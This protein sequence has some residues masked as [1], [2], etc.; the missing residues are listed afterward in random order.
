MSDLLIGRE[1]IEEMSINEMAKHFFALKTKIDEMK[2]AQA[3]VQGEFDML[4]KG[5][6]PDKMDEME[7][8][9]VNIAGVG[10]ISLRAEVY[11]SVKK[12]QK[13][14]AFEWLAANGFGSLIKD[15]VNASSLKAL[16]K[17]QLELGNSFP[18]DIFSVDPF[19]MAT[20]TKG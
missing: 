2:K 14:E 12:D 20:L 9:T 10:R 4:R 15:T 5:I 18:D 8:T 7:F 3:L 11:A 1:A 19:M 13:E 17:E 16:V 6:L